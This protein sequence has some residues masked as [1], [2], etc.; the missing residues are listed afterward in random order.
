[1]PKN[2]LDANISE[3]KKE[4]AYDEVNVCQLGHSKREHDNG[5]H[6]PAQSNVQYTLV[7]IQSSNCLLYTSRCV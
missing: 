2:L 6:N 4:E 5:L 7:L 3:V 1:M